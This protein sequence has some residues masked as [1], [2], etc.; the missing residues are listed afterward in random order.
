MESPV[1][2]NQ[3]T[4]KSTISATKTFSIFR[5]TVAVPFMEAPNNPGIF[6][7][8][9]IQLS[10]LFGEKY[11]YERASLEIVNDTNAKVPGI[12]LKFAISLRDTSV[13]FFNLLYYQE[14][15]F[16]KNQSDCLNEEFCC[17]PLEYASFFI[18]CY[19]KEFLE[20]P[21]SLIAHYGAMLLVQSLSWNIKQ[22]S[23]KFMAFKTLVQHV[24]SARNRPFVHEKDENI[25][26][27][28]P[29]KLRGLNA[30]NLASFCLAAGRLPNSIHE[31]SNVR[32]YDHARH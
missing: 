27:G 9:K 6:T 4:I 29:K 17:W 15:I 19:Q 5:Q 30:I 21:S 3:K 32:D 7:S 12:N 24:L 11:F 16:N 13:P 22:E 26:E 23:R 2:M 10:D 1:S 28:I 20:L 31:L 8:G 14:E 25:M 18:R